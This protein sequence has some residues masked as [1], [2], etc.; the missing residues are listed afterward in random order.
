[1]QYDLQN[2]N[3]K[4]KRHAEQRAVPAHDFGLFLTRKLQFFRISI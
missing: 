2:L 4:E 3:Y 1:M